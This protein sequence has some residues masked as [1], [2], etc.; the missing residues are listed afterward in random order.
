MQ[1][2][3]LANVIHGTAGDFRSG[4]AIREWCA[5]ITEATGTMWRYVRVDQADFDAHKPATVADLTRSQS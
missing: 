1:E 3:K 2:R 4:E 5:R